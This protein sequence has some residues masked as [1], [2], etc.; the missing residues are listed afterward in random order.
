M[1][2]KC[3][4]NVS[5]ISTN[6]CIHFAY[7]IRCHSS[8][9]FVYKMY[10][11]VCRNVVY[12]LYTF[13]IHFVYISCIHLVQFL[14]TKC[15]HSFRVGMLDPPQ[16]LDRFEYHNFVF[17]ETITSCLPAQLFTNCYRCTSKMQNRRM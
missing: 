16:I 8:S 2:T 13:C 7:K 17:A 12:I 10:T 6:V 4:Q 5:N 11:K 3:I 9:N 15:I 14:Y 1:C